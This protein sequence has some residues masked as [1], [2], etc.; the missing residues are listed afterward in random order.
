[1]LCHRVC[2]AR[3]IRA[4]ELTPAKQ[5]IKRCLLPAAGPRRLPFGVAR[6]I[7]M[8]I[9]FQ[10]QTRT[11][12]GLYEIELNR[13]LRRMLTPGVRAFDIG[14]QHGYDALVIAKHTGSPVAAFECDHACVL[15]MRASFGL[16]PGLGSLVTP[17]EALVGDRP[18]ELGIDEYAF[19][20]GF[21]PDF[22]KIDIEGGELSALRSA[23]RLLA[24][25]GPC[26]VL[27]VHS[28]RLEHACGR[29]LVEHGYRPTIVH[30]RRVWPDHRPTQAVNRWL[31]APGR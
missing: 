14:A 7:R 3:H 11:Y 24:E 19:V 29:L 23:H 10:V 6:G 31:V 8:Q 13:H 5:A 16:N 20:D 28:A 26:I 9:D 30:Q 22:L 12:L 27:E 15:G 21:V 18:G 1:M 4:S 17:V 2:E 25:R